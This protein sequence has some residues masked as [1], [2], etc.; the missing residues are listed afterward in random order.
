MN[1]STFEIEA[2][3]KCFGS[4]NQRQRVPVIL[5]TGARISSK[6]LN[7]PGID[8][9]ESIPPAYVTLQAG[10]TTYLTYWP[11]RLHSLVE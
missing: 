6:R 11:T 4:V 5:R 9:K 7:N 10:T 1:Y 8:Y 2:H 3:L